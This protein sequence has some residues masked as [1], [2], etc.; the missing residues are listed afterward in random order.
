MIRLKNRK[1]GYRVYSGHSNRQLSNRLWAFYLTKKHEVLHPVGRALTSDWSKLSMREFEVQSE[2]FVQST[3]KNVLID[4][5]YKTFYGPVISECS[6]CTVCYS[7][8]CKKLGQARFSLMSS[9][10][11]LLCSSVVQILAAV[12]VTLGWFSYKTF[13]HTVSSCNLQ[14][15]GDTKTQAATLGRSIYDLG[16]QV[17]TLKHRLQ[18]KDTLSDLLWQGDTQG[19]GSVSRGDRRSVSLSPL[20]VKI[21]HL[22]QVNNLLITQCS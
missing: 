1:K 19:R 15:R 18:L 6:S 5:H 20:P 7:L 8:W 3:T 22:P 2:F 21:S 10:R 16:T 17:V 9:W 13:R 4:N 12:L 14:R 11:H